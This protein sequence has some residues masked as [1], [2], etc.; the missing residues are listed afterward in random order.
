MVTLQNAER[1]TEEKLER[2][3]FLLICLC[4]PGPSPVFDSLCLPSCDAVSSRPSVPAC[5]RLC[6]GTRR[7]QPEHHSERPIPA[8][9][10]H[11]PG[12]PQCRT[13]NQGTE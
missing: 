3:L 13:P 1:L 9:N 7:R 2:K 10:Q 11:A 8:L 5:A 6:G 4:D 12:R